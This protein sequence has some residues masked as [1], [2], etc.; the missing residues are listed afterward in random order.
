MLIG[1]PIGYRL[2]DLS[3]IISV[4]YIKV[5]LLNLHWNRIP[6][7]RFNL[8]G[9]IEVVEQFECGRM[10]DCDGGATRIVDSALWGGIIGL[11]ETCCLLAATYR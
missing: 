2:T 7:L 10:K 4:N 1:Q 11:V 6:L 5:I 8:K 3:S 9:L